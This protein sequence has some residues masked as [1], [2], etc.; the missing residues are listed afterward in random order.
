VLDLAVLD[1]SSDIFSR[2][3]K[4]LVHAKE[5]R[6]E[7][8]GGIEDVL[9]AV[10][11]TRS[12]LKLSDFS[13]KQRQE[14]A[15]QAEANEAKQA[16]EDAEGEGEE[17]GEEN[18]E[19]EASARTLLHMGDSKFAEREYMLAQD[20]YTQFVHLMQVHHLFDVPCSIQ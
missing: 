14:L 17:E 2:G 13:F 18:P 11:G 20:L 8:T 15:A 7:V 4:A 19:N 12:V 3:G 5:C 1:H 6:E 9:S 10:A 16:A